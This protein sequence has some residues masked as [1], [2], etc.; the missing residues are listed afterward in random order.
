VLQNSHG[1]QAG[2]LPNAEVFEIV[3]SLRKLVAQRVIHVRRREGIEFRLHL[4]R[5]HWPLEQPQPVV[6]LPDNR[7]PIA[8]LDDHSTWSFLG[9]ASCVLVGVRQDFLDLLLDVLL[10]VSS[11][12]RER[13]ALAQCA[14]R[15][16]RLPWQTYYRPLGDVTPELPL[17]SNSA[18][19]VEVRLEQLTQGADLSNV[20]GLLAEQRDEILGRWLVASG[21]QPFHAGRRRAAVADQIP[22]LFD[23]LVALLQRAAPRWLTPGPPLDNRDV[24]AAAQAHAEG[25]FY[26]GLA[27]AE[28]IAEFR[29]LR[30]EIGRALR[31]YLPRGARPDDVIGAELLVHDA[32]DGAIS[33]TLAGLTRQIEELREEFQATLVHDLRQPIASIKGHQQLALRR[34]NDAEPDLA[35]VR[36]LLRR[37]EGETDRLAHLVGQLSDASR[38]ALGRLEVRPARCDLHALLRDVVE[39][40][41]PAASGRIQLHVPQKLDAC[42]EFDVELLERVLANLLSNA[43]KYSA[44]DAS[45]LVSL[46]EAND[47]LHIA[48]RDNGIGVAPDEVESLFQRY[49][50]AKGAIEHGVEGLGLGLYLSRGIVEAHGGRIWAES[51]GKDQGTTF[52]LLLPR[53]HPIGLGRT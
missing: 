47:S 18:R 41:D 32:L 25:R 50:R 46:T 15:H 30:Q 7:P 19:G 37:A 11:R 17:S 13:A 20:A 21:A 33:L 24:L 29:L 31:L 36:N 35:R 43:L 23:A 42:G 28:I 26:Q 5:W 34:L 2:Q 12:R 10:D 52:H 8:L 38:L 14:F 51:A 6:C 4:D 3:D 39:R 16:I 45:V 49:S 44:A 27:A 48:V 53:H 9:N 22:E 1:E 40:A